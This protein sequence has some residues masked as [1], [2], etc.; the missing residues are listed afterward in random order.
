MLH[1]VVMAGGSGTRFWPASRQAQPKQLLP[2]AGTDSMIQSTVN[3]FS[4]WVPDE[5]KL[6]VTNRRLVAGIREQLPQLPADAVMGEPC[7]RDTAPCVGVAAAW[8]AKKDPDAIMV[9]T[10]ADHVIQPEAKF[11]E[12]IEHAVRL[13][14][15]E[16]KR[17]ITF[18]I[19]PSYPAES[20]GYIQCG[21]PLAE[22]EQAFRVERFREKPKADVAQAY[23]DQGGFYWNAG[24]FVWK[25][26]TI[27][28]ELKAHE[29]E[30][31]AHIEKIQQA[32]GNPDFPEVF[33]NEFAAIVG[34]SI[35]YAVMENAEE[36]VVIEAPFEWD[37]V[38]SWLALPRLRGTDDDG[39]TI[40][41]RHLGIETK[42]SVIRSEGDHLI[43]TVGLKDCLVVHTPDA[44][45][46]ADKTQEERVREVVKQLEANGWDQYL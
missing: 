12:A 1:A 21:E 7:K 22:A 45:L 29:P 13:V 18:G 35:D 3:R 43:V 11:R 31:Y 5:H 33:Q 17:L 30:M 23:L 32:I 40:V 9:V 37:D 15:A 42:D 6:V 46:V 44:T 27:L 19:K 41:G 14:E 34:K 10:P 20:F 2:L 26:Q 39:N 25:A 8:V 24:I 38:G 4:G 16:P 28:D 36:V